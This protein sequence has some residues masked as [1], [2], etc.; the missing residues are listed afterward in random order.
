M[1]MGVGMEIYIRLVVARSLCLFGVFF[2]LG[3]CMYV[4]LF[5]VIR[6]S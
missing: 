6:D 3:V 2:T 5:V 1:G 4:T